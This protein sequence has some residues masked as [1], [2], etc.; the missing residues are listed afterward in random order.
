MTSGNEATLINKLKQQKV[1]EIKE[2]EWVS[3]A[4]ER[5]KSIAKWQ[6]KLKI[7]FNLM[8]QGRF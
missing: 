2:Q 5:K 1:L 6:N 3:D 7:F 4:K 8:S